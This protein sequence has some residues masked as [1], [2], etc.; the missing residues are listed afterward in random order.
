MKSMKIVL[1]A[2]LSNA[3][4]HPYTYAGVK[5]P[6]DNMTRKEIVDNA[7]TVHGFGYWWGKGRWKKNGTTNDKLAQCDGPA[8][9]CPNCSFAIRSNATDCIVSGTGNNGKCTTNAHCTQANYTCQM[10]MCVHAN[11]TLCQVK[12]QANANT[13]S[14]NTDCPANY[15]CVGGTMYP[16]RLFWRR[17]FGNGCQILG[18][19]YRKLRCY[20]PSI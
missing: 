15:N 8:S 5:S 16:R 13:C 2:L 7:K 19:G 1:I 18:V 20:G 11:C 12:T 17:L 9:S 10:G 4:V 3:L 14:N 6:I